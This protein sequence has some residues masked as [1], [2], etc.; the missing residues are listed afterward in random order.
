MKLIL[1]VLKNVPKLVKRTSKILT[2]VLCIFFQFSF[3]YYILLLSLLIFPLFVSNIWYL[4]EWT[5]A[6]LWQLSDRCKD[7]VK[8]NHEIWQLACVIEYLDRFFTHSY[9]CLVSLCKK[10]KKQKV[11][12]ID[13]CH[14][15]NCK[16]KSMR[17]KTQWITFNDRSVLLAFSLQI[18]FLKHNI[19]KT[20]NHF[21]TFA[22]TF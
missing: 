19:Y 9:S 1:N 17:H 12:S 7:K 22:G 18:S 10:M 13:F 14:T 21:W 16:T 15:F 2:L 11:R 3:I 6:Q 5:L 20:N 8:Y 4:F